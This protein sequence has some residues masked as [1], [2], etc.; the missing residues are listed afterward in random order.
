MLF[1]VVAY[2][3]KPYAENEGPLHSGSL[4]AGAFCAFW[5]I[6]SYGYEKWVRFL[7]FVFGL[8]VLW[9]MKMGTCNLQ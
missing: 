6:F 7:R 2:T 8:L 9:G 3:R 5:D 4:F 1:F